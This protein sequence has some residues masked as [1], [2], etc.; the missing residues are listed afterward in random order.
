MYIPDSR[1]VVL[2]MNSTVVKIICNRIFE[3]FQKKIR[4]EKQLSSQLEYNLKTVKCKK[5]IF[6][7]ITLVLRLLQFIVSLLD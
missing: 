1:V 7:T 5:A 6:Y 2:T 3:E 4:L